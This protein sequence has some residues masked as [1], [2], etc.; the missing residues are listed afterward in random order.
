MYFLNKVVAWQ[1]VS[2]I[3]AAAIAGIILATTNTHLLIIYNQLLI[4]IGL[5]VFFDSLVVLRLERIYTK[6]RQAIKARLHAKTL[7]NI[8]T[9][10]LI[11]S[12]LSVIEIFAF[13]FS[14]C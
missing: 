9:G 1:G 6:A 10:W 3:S 13:G 7:A 5:S 2:L 8:K 12:L 4:G 11:V 14:F